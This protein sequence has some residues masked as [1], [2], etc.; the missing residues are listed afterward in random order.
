MTEIDKWIENKVNLMAKEFRENPDKIQYDLFDENPRSFPIA[1]DIYIPI[2]NNEIIMES[3]E[4][5]KEYLDEKYGAILHGIILSDHPRHE[6]KKMNY[7]IIRFLYDGEYEEPFAWNKRLG[8]IGI[9]DFFAQGDDYY[10]TLEDAGIDMMDSD[11]EAE[12]K[13]VRYLKSAGWQF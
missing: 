8:Y 4:G 1:L 10:T 6:N 13:L 2:W 5:L 3:L 11:E 12:E 9:G 7:Y